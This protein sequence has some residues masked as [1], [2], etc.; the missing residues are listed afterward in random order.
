L[1]FL[2][3]SIEIKDTT[4]TRTQIWMNLV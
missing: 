3:V 4:L 1:I 2:V